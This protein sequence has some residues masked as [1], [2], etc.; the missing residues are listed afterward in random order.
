MHSEDFFSGVNR[1]AGIIRTHESLTEG[2]SALEK[3]SARLEEVEGDGHEYYIEAAKRL[4]RVARLI[5]EPALMRKESR[6]GHYRED[7]PCADEDF[8]LHSVQ[9]KGHPISTAP[10]NSGYFDF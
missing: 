7:Y 2:L 10:V 5:I 8:L 3:I 1:C 9:Q 4:I 6:G